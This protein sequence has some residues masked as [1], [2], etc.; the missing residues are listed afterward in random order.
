MKN[1]KLNSLTIS[2]F[3]LC[4]VSNIFRYGHLFGAINEH[5]ACFLS[6]LGCALMIMGIF[7]MSKYS[8]NSK[9]RQWKLRLIEKA[10]G[11]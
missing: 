10:K 6:G 3:L 8:E 9:L 7:T 1:N 5:F 4:S 2:G 11:K